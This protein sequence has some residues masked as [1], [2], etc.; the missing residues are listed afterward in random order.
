MET[1]YIVQGSSGEY[2]DHI[3]WIVAAFRREADAQELI[4]KASARAREL[5][6]HRNKWQNIYPIPT[7][8]TNEFDPDMQMDSTGVNYNCYEAELR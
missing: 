7:K 5:F 8:Y 3:E 4:K 6:I 2:S 1:I